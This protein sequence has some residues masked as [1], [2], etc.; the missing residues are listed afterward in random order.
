MFCLSDEGLF[1]T[2]THSAIRITRLLWVRS[3]RV[4][5]AIINSTSVDLDLGL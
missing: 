1:V 5:V 3:W 2:S 4:V